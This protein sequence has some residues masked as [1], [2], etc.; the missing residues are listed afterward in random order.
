MKKDPS[1]PRSGFALLVLAFFVFGCG[2][3]A[4]QESENII[5]LMDLPGEKKVE[6]R[7]GDQL[8]TSYIYPDQLKKPV[9]YPIHTAGG[10]V[11]NRGFPLE[12][13]A[14]ERTDH[15][16]H[17]GLWMNY[18][19]VN[20]LDFWNN[21]AARPEADKHLYGTIVHKEVRSTQGKRDQGMLDVINEWL[22]PGG[23]VLL[24]E[25]TRFVFAAQQNSRTIDRITTLQALGREVSFKDNKEGMFALRVA[26][27]L[28]LPSENSGDLAEA[29]G[30]YVSS[31]GI[32]GADVWGTRARWMKLYSTI[33]DEKVT[34]V[35]FDHPDN[36]GYPTYWHARGY[37]LF[38]ANP[39]G[40]A[41][42]SGGEQVLDFTL[43]PYESVSFKYRLLVHSGSELSPAYIN[44]MAEEFARVQTPAVD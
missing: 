11:I 33:E 24:K 42:F 27:P 25:Y 17:V 28:E 30:N 14:G 16:H 35:I 31:E 3:R 39:L 8:F 18:G 1:S 7:V 20:G 41:V 10:M 43:A 26:R 32:Q 44:A 37:G 34:L 23:D 9:L 15:P 4:T 21:S 40:Q 6:V 13:R 22:T 2:Q 12:P 19:D 29:C 5:R 38:A 36:V